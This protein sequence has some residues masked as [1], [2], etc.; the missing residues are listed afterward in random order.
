LTGD[1]VSLEVIKK[2][3]KENCLILRI[4][5]TRGR[6]SIG[7]LMAN[8]KGAVLEETDLLEWS[9]GERFAAD[10]P[11]ELQLKPF[12]IRTFKLKLGSA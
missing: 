9:P 2:A 6:H 11:V 10:Q 4:V 1:G 12:E 5:E 7:R 8:M 3:E